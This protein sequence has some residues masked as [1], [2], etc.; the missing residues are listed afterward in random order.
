[1]TTVITTIVMTKRKK[2][3]PRYTTRWSDIPVVK[4]S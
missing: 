2:L 3:S 1:M 4:C